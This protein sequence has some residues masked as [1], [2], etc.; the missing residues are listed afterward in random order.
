MTRRALNVVPRGRRRLAVYKRVSSDEQEER[1]TIEAQTLYLDERLKGEDVEIVDEY[2]D[3][4]TS[5]TLLFEDRPGAARLLRDAAAGRFDQVV[6]YKFDRLAREMFVQ[7]QAQR[8]LARYGVG[9]R[10]V[11][12]NLVVDANANEPFVEYMFQQTGSMA[13]LERANIRERTMNGKHRVAF[14]GRV[15]NGRIPLGYAVDDDHRL[16]PSP[17]PIAA[18]GLSE[19]EMVTQIF[20]RVAAGQ[21][22]YQVA[23]W[24]RAAGVTSPPKMW[25]KK[26]STLVE[27]AAGNYG[28]TGR[29]V[30]ETIR[31]PTYKGVRVLNF[32]RREVEQQA[33]ALVTEQIWDAANARLKTNSSWDGKRDGYIYLLSRKLR[34]GV[35][36]PSGRACGSLYVG[37]KANAYRYYTCCGVKSAA[38]RQ[39]GARCGARLLRAERVEEALW[40]HLRWLVEH[41]AEALEQAAAVL[42]EQR[43]VIGPDF[44]KRRQELRRKLDRIEQAQRFLREELS[45]GERDMADVREDLRVNGE[46][47]AQVHHDL[48]LLEDERAATAALEDQ[49]TAATASLAALREAMALMD[50]VQDRRE[51]RRWLEQLVREIQ[52]VD[53][54]TRAPTLHVKWRWMRTDAVPMAGAREFTNIQTVAIFEPTTTI[55]LPPPQAR[56]A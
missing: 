36:L 9:L 45:V 5:G 18:L 40:A 44:D 7:L 50:L 37:G 22:T 13:Q 25:N 53:G 14:S 21:S 42:A 33:P 30:W 1:H 12:E 34:C 8:Q 15:V 10:S 23:D 49:Y 4:G 29:R 41:P 38:V 2:V 6:V 51:M 17:R 55:T 27:Q 3:D 31:R 52:V 20:Q 16:I 11:A 56:S 46:L 32:E 28:W 47:R 19:A 43:A 48:E 35:T 24:L 39:R 26:S 54:E